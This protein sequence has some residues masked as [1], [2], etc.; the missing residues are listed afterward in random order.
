MA[1]KVTRIAGPLAAG[2]VLWACAGRP[3]P[4]MGSPSRGQM[5]RHFDLAV[6]AGGHAMNGDV[7]AFRETAEALA[8]L[9]PAEDLAPELIRQLGPLRWEAR[10]GANAADAGEAALAAAR[11]ARTCGRC[12]E[13]NGVPLG[14]RFTVGGP[15]PSGSPARH[16]AGLA[17]AARLLWNGL[18]GPSDR[19]WIAGAE[20]LT[21]L[22]LLPEGLPT[23][24]PPGD[25][26]AAGL[27]LRQLA[28]RATHTREADE[29]VE[30]LAETWTTCAGCHAKGR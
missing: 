5:V 3:Q 11:I 17:W 6:E 18:V 30:V 20:G 12:H 2:L 28:E 8:D 24:L 13:A 1:G 9:E 21:E 19:T 26:R 23:D 14:E 4:Y 15:P 16:M 27:R 25:V 29:R 10:E 22:G 7:E